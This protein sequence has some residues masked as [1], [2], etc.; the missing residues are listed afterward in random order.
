MISTSGLATTFVTLICFPY[1]HLSTARSIHGL[2]Y[3]DLN[4]FGI[5]SVDTTANENKL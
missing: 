3:S 4:P 2:K 5:D 1:S